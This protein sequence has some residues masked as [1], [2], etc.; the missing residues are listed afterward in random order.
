MTAVDLP[1]PTLL[2]PAH[3]P[4]PQGTIRSVTTFAILLNEGIGDAVRVSLPAPPVEEVTAG[5]QIPQ[6]PG[7]RPRRLEIVSCLS[8]GRAQAD[9]YR[10]T[11]KV[12]AAFDGFPHPLRVAVMGCVANGPGEAREAS[13]GVSRGNGKGQ[14][15]VDGHVVRT[16]PESRIVEALL[17]EALNLTGPADTPG[18]TS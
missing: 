16:V 8:C 11:A 5:V 18:S 4:P 1:Q 14:I 15:F 2:P 6:A 17:E 12:Q 9:V 10:L 3:H 13:L 7:L